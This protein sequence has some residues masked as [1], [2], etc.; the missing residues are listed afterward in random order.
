MPSCGH[1][2]TTIMNGPSTRMLTLL[3]LLQDGRAWPGAEL[4]DRLG[5]TPRTMRRDVDRLRELG[6]PVESA[7]GPGGNYQLV[8]GQAMP[9]LVLPD[10]EAVAT[11]NGL[12]LAETAQVDGTSGALRKL[13]R[14]LP[15][16]LR[17]RVEA[18][19]ATTSVRSR[20]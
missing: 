7:R 5:T 4:A 16:R 11:V 12:R 18:V 17:H 19:A 3:S 10:D 14:V 2:M 1:I 6:Y 8:A 9:P 15:S 13:T 20:S